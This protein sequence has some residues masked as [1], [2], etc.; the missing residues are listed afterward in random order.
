MD[1]FKRGSLAYDRLRKVIL[2]KLGI[3]KV[4]LRKVTSKNHNIRNKKLSVDFKRTGRGEGA[5]GGWR[6]R[7]KFYI[8]TF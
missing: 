3:W 1:K 4:S 6:E 7:C 8:S 2:R 5:V